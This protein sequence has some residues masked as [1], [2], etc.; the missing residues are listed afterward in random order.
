[1]AVFFPDLTKIISQLQKTAM[2]LGKPQRRNA[3]SYRDL[4]VHLD[5]SEICAERVA[6]AVALAKRE[7]ARLTG[8]AL[9]LESTISTY[10]GVDFPKSLTEAQQDIVRQA[11]QSA[12]DKFEA[13]AKEAGIDHQARIVT[14]SATKA[15]ARLA[16][17]ARHADLI[18]VGQPNPDEK[19]KAFQE[20]ML[21]NII[22]NSGRPVYVVPYIGRHEVKNRKAVI[23]WDGSKKAV[24][25]VNDA[26]PLL[27]ARKEVIVLVVNP[28]KRSAE[29]GGQQGENLVAHLER[30]DINVKVAER[31]NPDLSVD[32]II[33]N[34]IS[35]SGADL[36]VMGAFGHSRLREKAFGGVTDSI[37]HQ[38][39]V[40][41][42]MS[43]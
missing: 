43:E 42:L 2:S 41:V 29:Y 31:T 33:Q 39:I 16:F 38:M 35:D 13:A 40:P 12:V 34:F 9:A 10:I 24:R 11:A 32:T 23:A 26:I 28:K 19:G 15:P 21:E 25:A 22:H 20:S 36:L 5:D 8:I 30:Y 6:A 17:F 1:M 27:Q 14:C 18:F 7:G 3:M 37:L 4:L